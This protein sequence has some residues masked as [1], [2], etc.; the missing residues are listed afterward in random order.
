MI[1]HGLTPGA[2][3]MAATSTAAQALDLAEHIGTVEQGKLADLLIVDGDP[4][5]EPQ[6]LTDPGRIWLVLQLGVPVAGR[7]LERDAGVP[8]SEPLIN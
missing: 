7:A 6:L 4:L 3:L 5:A 8:A 1:R 2:A